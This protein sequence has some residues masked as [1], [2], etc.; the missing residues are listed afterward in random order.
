MSRFVCVH[1]HFYQPPRE[2]PWLE[3]VQREDSAAPYHDWNQRITAECYGPNAHARILESDGRI[4][5]IVSNYERMSFNF[6]PTLLSWMQERAPATYEA[7]LA[8]DRASRARFGGH[9]SALAQAYSHM[10]LPLADA[11]DKR[12]QVLWGAGDFERRFGRRPEGMWLPET[13]ADLATLEALADAGI[14][15]TVLAPRQAKRVRAPNS[16]AWLD[17]AKA[18]L[19]VRRPYWV[20]LPSG[21][22]MSVYFYDGAVSQAV[23]FEGLLARG[24][25]L[26]DRLTAALGSD[27]PDGALSHVATDGETY[28]HHHRFGE[29]ALAWA[30]DRID[31][32]PTVRLTNYAEH[33]ALH[34]AEWE[35]EIVEGSSWSCAHGVE[36]WRSDCGCHTGGRAGWTQAWRA[37]LRE[38][39]DLLR[40]RL[41]EVYESKAKGLLKDPWAAR[42]AYI[43]V[44]LDRSPENITRFLAE[45]AARRLAPAD[46]VLALRLLGIQR[47][48]ML[49]YTSCGWFFNDLAGLETVQILRYAAR[50]IELA[51]EV[52]GPD[53]SEAFVAALAKARSNDPEEG[54]GRRLYERRVLP[55]QA[56]GLTA[57]ARH[58]AAAVVEERPKTS[59]IDAWEVTAEDS[60]R[61]RQGAAR[62]AV[63][64]L[65]VVSVITRAA[66][67]A[68]YCF[69]LEGLPLP[70]GAVAF[71]PSLKAYEAMLWETTNLFSKGDFAGLRRALAKHFPEGPEARHGLSSD[72]ERRVAERVLSGA[73]QEAE[74]AFVALY[75]RQAPML[76]ALAERG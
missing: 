65:S 57:A 52:G 37:P 1:G 43:T 54:D 69:L 28:G 42:D 14:V 35:A 62:L 58:G 15:F 17:A 4:A 73:A 9:G 11:R 12:T 3:T 46:E 55:A 61:L 64:R 51:K 45:H 74:A 21:R 2:N 13:A 33:L 56:D 66:T 6:G 39:L 7:V 25:H 18:G 30:L 41:R 16:R 19:D 71:C 31:A 50:A 59:R 72:E 53:L 67:Q 36:R 10:I 8:A 29:M 75:E 48:A 47:H 68:S 76:R 60:R 22:R 34:P 23:A 63:G 20:R 44:I 40:D 32:D 49:M 26:A 24:E 38:A 5:S 70:E 27:A